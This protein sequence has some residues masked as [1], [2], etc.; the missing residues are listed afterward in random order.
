MSVVTYNASYTLHGYVTSTYRSLTSMTF[1][2]MHEP[3]Y[4]QLVTLQNSVIDFF[5]FTATKALHEQSSHLKKTHKLTVN[6]EETNLSETTTEEEEPGRPSGAILSLAL[7][8]KRK[9]C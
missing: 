6:V 8:K 1:L 5:S 7:G 3:F 2:W 9:S 4:L